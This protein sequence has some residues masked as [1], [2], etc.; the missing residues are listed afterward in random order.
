MLG[1]S[2]VSFQLSVEEWLILVCFCGAVWIACGFLGAVIGQCRRDLGGG[3]LLGLVFGP[4]G[5]IAALGLDGRPCCP[6]CG[7]RLDSMGRVCQHCRV[8]LGWV[9]GKAVLE[10]PG[11]VAPGIS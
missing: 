2:V 3:L 4:L 8:L 5:V 11:R 10:S 6:R 7:G 1:L 9:N